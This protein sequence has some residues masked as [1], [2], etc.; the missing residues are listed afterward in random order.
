MSLAGSFHIK[1]CRLVIEG[2]GF[3]TTTRS[4]LLD[5]ARVVAQPVGR[6]REFINDTVDNVVN[7]FRLSISVEAG[8][9]ETGTD[10]ADFVNVLA[11]SLA[12]GRTVKF[13]P[14]AD[15]SSPEITC[16]V[17][18]TPVDLEQIR[19]GTRWRGGRLQ[20][21]SQGLVSSTTL[22]LFKRTTT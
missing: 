1:K 7:G 11:E 13:R 16:V 3:S 12:T 8:W 5:R 4:F 10:T 20:M 19:E 15:K 6:R 18:M 2:P 22:L 17:D 14:D 21:T 9:W